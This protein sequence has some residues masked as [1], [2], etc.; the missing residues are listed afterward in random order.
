LRAGSSA[1]DSLRMDI[2]GEL[3]ETGAVEREPAKQKS[4]IS[5]AG[6][7]QIQSTRR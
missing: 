1:I 5:F 2:P 4:K 6:S 7:D 3:P